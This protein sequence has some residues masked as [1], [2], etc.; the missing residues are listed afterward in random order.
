MPLPPPRLEQVDPCDVSGAA[1]TAP[2]PVA[3]CRV[4]LDLIGK[5]PTCRRPPIGHR[6]SRFGSGAGDFRDRR[7]EAVAL[8]RR[9]LADNPHTTLQVVLEPAADPG[10]LTATVLESLLAACHA[11][12]SY[13]DWYY[14]LHPAGLL[15]AKR[16]VVVAP[17]GRRGEVDRAWIE[18]VGD[19]ATLIWRE[20]GEG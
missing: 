20:E 17:A 12:N 19:C 10:R 2:Q 7:H 6:R 14:S 8:V 18:M 11:D 16:L 3:G 1:A 9:L 4:D 5:A 15:G 13:L